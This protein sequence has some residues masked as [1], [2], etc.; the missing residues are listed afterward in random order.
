M[1]L[2]C[3][4]FHRIQVVF[5]GHDSFR[6]SMT[7]EAEDFVGVKSFKAKGKRLT[8]YT[9]ER[10]EELEPTR[11]PESETAEEETENELAADLPETPDEENGQMKLF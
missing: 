7:I 5:G 4:A 6:E 11:M 10:F 3:Q 8:T 2:T 1:L 9:V